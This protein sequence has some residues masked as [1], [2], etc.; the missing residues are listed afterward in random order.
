MEACI[1]LL[2]SLENLEN[3]SV[4]GSGMILGMLSLPLHRFMCLQTPLQRAALVKKVIVVRAALS[5]AL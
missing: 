4:P 3:P 1:G 5:S 2:L